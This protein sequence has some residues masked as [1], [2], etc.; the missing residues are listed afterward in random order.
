MNAENA[1]RNKS[2]KPQFSKRL[3]QNGKFLSGLQNPA[4]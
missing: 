3:Q 1:E 4:E 2:K